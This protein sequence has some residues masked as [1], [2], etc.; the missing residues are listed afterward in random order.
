MSDIPY[1]N[2]V[3]TLR[4]IADCTQPDIAFATNQ[5][6][7]YLNDPGMEH[8]LALKHCYMYLKTTSNVWLQLGSTN[9]SIL[10]GYTDADSMM[11]EGHCAISGYA[12]YLSDSLVLWSSKRQTLVANSTYEAELIALARGTQEAIVLTHLAEE[13][14]QVSDAPI[15]IYC[16]NDAVIQTVTLDELKYLERT[17]HLD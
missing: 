11:Q 3:G 6:A 7:K 4:Y 12:F 10:N 16:N 8:Y 15:N 14:L 13:I 5:L 17:K 9:Q 2:M 1:M